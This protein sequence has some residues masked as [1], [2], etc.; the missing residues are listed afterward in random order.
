MRYTCQHCGVEDSYQP[1][2]GRTRRFCSTRCRVAAH[3]AG[4]IPV[5]MTR[6]HQWT[7]ADG[8]RPIRCDGSSA[9]ST[10]RPTWGDF[11]DV[12]A[13]G[14]GDGFGIMLGDGLGCYD[15]DHVS[16]DEVRVFIATVPERIVYVE[17]SVSGDGA[18]VFIEADEG[19]GSRRRGVERYTRARFIRMTGQTFGR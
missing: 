6:R 17:R 11:A 18:H 16:D 1:G 4:R 10:D 13:S 15:L 8:K 7:R 2:R 19:R 12:K 3:R 5:E 9:S 14:A